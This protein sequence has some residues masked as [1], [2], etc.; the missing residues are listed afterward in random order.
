M[1]VDRE[2]QSL[3]LLMRV[4]SCSRAELLAEAAGYVL[5]S[6]QSLCNSAASPAPQKGGL[7]QSRM[8]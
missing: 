3:C 5:S 1:S 4:D 6:H 7:R 2:K 8:S